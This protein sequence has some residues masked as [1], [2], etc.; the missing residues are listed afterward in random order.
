MFRLSYQIKKSDIKFCSLK[1]KLE[2]SILTIYES[3]HFGR[4]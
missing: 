3:D 4:V 1:E 2:N